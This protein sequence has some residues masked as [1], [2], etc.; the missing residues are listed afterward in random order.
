MNDKLELKHIQSYQLLKGYFLEN[1][2]I[3]T[4]IDFEHKIISSLNNGNV[5]IKDFKPALRPLSDLTKEIEHNGEK[6]VPYNKLTKEIS[7]KAWLSE[8]KI[9]L[10]RPVYLPYFMVEKLFEWHFDVFN[11]PPE[12]WIDINTIK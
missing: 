12:L 4:G 10:S 9:N 8:I 6:F 5:L 2:D 3:V 11:L 1:L 7:N